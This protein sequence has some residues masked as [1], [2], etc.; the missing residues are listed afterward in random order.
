MKDQ[1]L[2][3]A[4]LDSLDLSTSKIVRRG[5]R[6][7]RRLPL[8]FLRERQELTQV[9]VAKRAKMT[10]SDISRAEQRHDCRVSTLDRYAKALGGKLR[11]LIEIDGH[12][13]PIALK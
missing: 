9:Q 4:D 13:Y 3:D 11:L 8:A 7:D 10:Q 6:L 12:L 1:D 2:S 5:P